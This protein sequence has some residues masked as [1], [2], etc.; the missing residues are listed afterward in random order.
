MLQNP[1]NKREIINDDVFKRI[2]NVDRMDMFK[3]NKLLGEHLISE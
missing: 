3:M 2:F 1:S